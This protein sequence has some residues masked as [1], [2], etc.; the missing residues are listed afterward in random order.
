MQVSLQWH[1]FLLISVEV[2]IFTIVTEK[3][4]G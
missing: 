3:G 4:G 2:A 1:S